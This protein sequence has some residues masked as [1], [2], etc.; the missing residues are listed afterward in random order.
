MQKIKRDTTKELF[1]AVLKLVKENGY[2]DKAEAIMDYVLPNE[3][4]D[5]SSEKY[6]ELSNYEFDFE[7][8]LQFGS[9]EGIYIS[10]CICGKYTETELKRYNHEKGTV[11]TE[12][13]RKI[14]TFKTLKTDVNSMRIMGELC[15]ALTFRRN[16]KTS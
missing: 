3:P 13:A 2:Y 5:Y 1:L 12:T 7:A 8:S 16:E 6:I 4:E 15:G 9:S 10:C 11:E 14:G